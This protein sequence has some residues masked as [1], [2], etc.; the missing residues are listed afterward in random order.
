MDFRERVVMRR[1][2]DA[3]SNTRLFPVSPRRHKN[4]ALAADDG[5]SAL[6]ADLTTALDDCSG[7]LGILKHMVVPSSANQA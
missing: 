3:R 4:H 7:G 2:F 1:M 5:I 6:F